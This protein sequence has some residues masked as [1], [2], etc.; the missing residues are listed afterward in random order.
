MDEEKTTIA[1]IGDGSPALDELIAEHSTSWL[2]S[3]WPS[4]DPIRLYETKHQR[5]LKPVV[6]KTELNLRSTHMGPT[7]NYLIFSTGR[8][9]ILIAPSLSGP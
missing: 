6:A 1:D 5:I 3:A 9:S 7:R 8:I 2:L 4:S